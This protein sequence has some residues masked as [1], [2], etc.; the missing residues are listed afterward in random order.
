MRVR[1]GGVSAFGEG[2][3]RWVCGE[4]NLATGYLVEKSRDDLNK[5]LK[6]HTF[7]DARL[8]RRCREPSPLRGIAVWE[9]VQNM[10]LCQFLAYSRGIR[11]GTECQT[12]EGSIGDLTIL[13]KIHKNRLTFPRQVL[14]ASHSVKR[15][16]EL[17]AYPE[18]ATVVAI[19]VC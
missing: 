18:E 7:G 4:R 10:V 11:R 3:R 6:R 15:S 19:V 5:W 1:A 17:A 9:D 14:G 2:R 12:D 13:P 16:V 8:G